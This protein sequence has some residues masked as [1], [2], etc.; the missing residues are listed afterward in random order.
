MYHI[1]QFMYYLASINDYIFMA[2]FHF[3]NSFLSTH[4]FVVHCLYTLLRIFAADIGA[5]DNY[6]N[7]AILNF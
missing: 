6:F 3:A 2:L 1:S 5:I 7:S 4:D